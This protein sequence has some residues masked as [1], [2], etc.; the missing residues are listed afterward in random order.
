M[1]RTAV[2][3]A[4]TETRRAARAIFADS[5]NTLALGLV[6]LMVGLPLVLLGPIAGFVAGDQ[7][8][9][10]EV[11]SDT[12][13]TVP[14]AVTG[15]VA[16]GVVGL[17]TLTVVRTVTSIADLDR[18]ACLLVSAP[19]WEVVAGLVLKE[20]A[21][22]ALVV[23][24][25]TLVVSV[26]FALGAGAPLVAL[27][28]L[29]TAL[30]VVVVAIPVGFALGVGLRHVLTVYEPV[31]QYR[32]LVFF[33]A[34]GLYFA[35]FVLGWFDRLTVVLFE[36]LGGTPL[37]WPGEAL[38]VGAPAV[39]G[40]PA[41]A[42]AGLLGACVLGLVGFVIAVR[43]SESHWFADPAMASTEETAVDSSDRLGALLAGVVSRPVRTV[44]VTAIRRTRRAPLRLAYVAYPLFGGVTLVVEAVQAGQLSMFAAVSLCVY[45]VW[46]AGALFTLNLPGDHGSALPSVLTATVSGRAVVTGTVL[47]GVLFALPFALVVPPVAGLASPLGPVETGLLTVGTVVGVVASPMLATGVGTR[48]PRFGTVRITSNR[49]AVMPGKLAFVV[50]SIAVLLLAGSGAALLRAD[51][52][53]GVAALLAAFLSTPPT[54]DLTLPTVVGRALAAALVAAGLVVSVF[55][56]RSAARQFDE[57]RLD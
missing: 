27:Y 7:L 35:G 10:G 5:T 46:A 6:V 26:A 55:S 24:G 56:A 16:L 32:T 53:D 50:Y 44:A 36:S 57:F 12:T 18:P 29:A 33:L 8:A 19:L 20:A 11:G 34:G 23:V 54:V 25:P 51:V 4:R 42:G 48:F 45:V 2:R 13:D 47:A 1:T 52:A 9:A 3:I 22:V 38:L 31:A 37:G 28:A 21:A 30:A 43:A 15:A 39:E 41:A 14:G 40:S 17:T 49:E